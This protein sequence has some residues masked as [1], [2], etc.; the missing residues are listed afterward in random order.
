MKLLVSINIDK[1]NA[2]PLYQV[3]HLYINGVQR[4][5]IPLLHMVG[6]LVGVLGIIL[7][8]FDETVAV[9]AHSL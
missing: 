8:Y 7:L 2:I 6:V 3:A 9:M 4:Q 1:N 5:L